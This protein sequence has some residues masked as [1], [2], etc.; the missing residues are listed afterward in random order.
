MGQVTGL[1]R[2][3]FAGSGRRRVLASWQRQLAA[4]WAVAI[5]IYHVAMILQGY[6][7]LDPTAFLWSHLGSFLVLVF[8][9]YGAGLDKSGRMN[10]EGWSMIGLSGAVMTYMFYHQ[11]RLLNRAQLGLDPTGLD[12]IVGV[13]LFL[14]TC[15][16]TRRVVGMPLV[17]VTGSFI[18]Y[19]VF[20]PVFPGLWRHEGI[21]MSRLV[22]SLSM[23][24]LGEGLWALPTEL[25]STVII[26]LVLFGGIISGLG[27]GKLFL[28][29]ANALLGKR[30]GGPAKVAVFASAAFGTISGGAPSNVAVTGTMTIPAMKQAGFPPH[31]AGAV[32]AVASTGGAI[33]P[34]VMG[35]TIFIMAEL[36]GIPYSK[37]LLPAAIPALLYYWAFF[38]QVDLESAKRGILGLP[39]ESLPKPWKVFLERGEFILPVLVLVYFILWGLTVYMAAIYATA[40]TMLVGLARPGGRAAYLRK[41]WS[42]TVEAMQT[43]LM[44]VFPIALA[45]VILTSIG[46]SG[47]GSKFAHLISLATGQSL[48]LAL[49]LGALMSLLLGMLTSI[50]VSYILVVFLVIPVAVQIGVL[51]MVA[52]FFSLYFASMGYITP[53]V[54]IACFVASAISGA[55]GMRIGLTSMRLAIAAFI[56]PFVFVYHPGLLLIGTPGEIFWSILTVTAG[57]SVLPVALTGWLKSRLGLWPRLVLA[58]ASLA[59]FWP[60]MLINVLGAVVGAAVLAVLWGWWPRR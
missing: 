41:L 2:A 51:P 9:H 12:L 22:S 58:A 36:V 13:V 1:L 4:C 48:F 50:T 60:S 5:T 44:V 30:R 40:A 53:P 35:A 15:E 3:I 46:S 54:A 19:N 14:L 49:V 57:F 31:Y 45:G 21:T 39:Q 6:W 52:H 7:G 42:G 23:G 10:A 18:A 28:D 16:A 59:L 29:L 47:F 20:G 55:N 27:A 56:L 43:M 11:G 38:L 37:L 25:S 32:E 33:T 17:W 24:V 26:T 8:L 34:P